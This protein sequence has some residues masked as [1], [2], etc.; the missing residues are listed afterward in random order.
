MKLCIAVVATIMSLSCTLL[1]GTCADGSGGGDVGSSCP[2]EVKY[3][4]DWSKC[5]LLST[6]LPGG[7]IAFS[8]PVKGDFGVETISATAGSVTVV[9]GRAISLS[10]PAMNVTVVESKTQTQTS[11]AFAGDLMFQTG[12]PDSKSGQALV[13]KC[14]G[15]FKPTKN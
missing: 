3:A 9:I 2:S 6:A 7:P 10:G 5:A 12:K 4:V 13:V 15:T 14:D 1:A 11:A 8:Q